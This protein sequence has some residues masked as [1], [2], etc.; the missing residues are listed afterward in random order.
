[1]DPTSYLNQLKQLMDFYDTTGV[2]GPRTGGLGDMNASNYAGDRLSFAERM[3]GQGGMGMQGRPGPMP[4]YF[5]P[6]QQYQAPSYT[7]PNSVPPNPAPQNPGLPMINGGPRPAPVATNYLQ[8][9]LGMA[10]GPRPTFT[11]GGVR[12]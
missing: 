3:L 4:N 8:Q 1:M 9:L 2:G 7:S 5:A 6:P 12:G 11:G 10:P